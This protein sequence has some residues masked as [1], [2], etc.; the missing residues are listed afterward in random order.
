MHIRDYINDI[1]LITAPLHPD[2]EIHIYVSC[3]GHIFTSKDELEQDEL[4][5]SQCGDY[6]LYIVGGSK[7]EILYE[8]IRELRRELAETEELLIEYA[9]MNN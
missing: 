1:I 5:C 4:I 7:E 2:T 8:C 6:S 3:T 9:E